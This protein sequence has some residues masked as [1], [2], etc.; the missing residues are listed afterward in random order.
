MP[1]KVIVALV[2][3]LV[4]PLNATFHDFPEGKPCS[5]KVIVK[6]LLE[7]DGVVVVVV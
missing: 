1:T 3:D 7:L 4:I 5:W 2:V 6:E